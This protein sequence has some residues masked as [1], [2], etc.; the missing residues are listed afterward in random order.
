MIVLCQNFR[1]FN[2]PVL[3]LI[4]I[5][6][7]KVVLGVN[8]KFVSSLHY[9]DNCVL[10]ATYDEHVTNIWIPKGGKILLVIF[11]GCVIDITAVNL[12]RNFIKTSA[13]C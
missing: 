3:V 7:V 10:L 6:K 5:V 4:L 2:I 9:Q 11:S 1:V 8:T 13:R 12:P